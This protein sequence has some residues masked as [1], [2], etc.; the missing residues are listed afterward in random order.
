MD[1]SIPLEI[2]SCRTYRLLTRN[3]LETCRLQGRVDYQLIYIASGRGYF[4]FHHSSD[5]TI[6]EA[7]NMVLYR[8]GEFQKY[9][10][11]GE[12]KTEVYWIH[13]TGSNVK[14]ILRQYGFPEMFCRYGLD[15]EKHVF[16]SGAKSFYAQSFEQIILELQ[17]QKEFYEES[18][19]LFL[20]HIIVM[21]GRHQCEL[22]HNRD[23][24]LREVEEVMIYFREHYHET[25]NIESLVEARGYGVRSFYR[26]FKNCTGLTPLQYLLEIRLLNAK[27][28]L[29][30]T[31]FQVNE[32]SRLVGY[33]NALYFSRLFHKHTGVSPKDYRSAGRK[34]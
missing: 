11:Y 18:A 23:I 2:N 9:E 1:K 15:P 12:D 19:A 14:N 16:S 26:K 31:N 10:Y 34:S 24:P 21:A 20:V 6:L 22:S 32:V 25:I 27:K 7:G 3:R 30:T 13:F 8:P 4:Y 5:P 28:L 33:D 17:L 29:E